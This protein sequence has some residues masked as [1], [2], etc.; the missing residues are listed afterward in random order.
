MDAPG[1]MSSP[2]VIWVN[3]CFIH[4]LLPSLDFVAEIYRKLFKLAYADFVKSAKWFIPIS[5]IDLQCY[6]RNITSEIYR[7][8]NSCVFRFRVSVQSQ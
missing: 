6:A 8:L 3:G 4:N 7:N 1:F 2:L 5:L